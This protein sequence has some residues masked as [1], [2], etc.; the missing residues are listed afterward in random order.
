MGFQPKDKSY[1]ENKIDLDIIRK[2]VGDKVDCSEADRI[3][4][5]ERKR[6]EDRNKTYT[7]EIMAD[8]CLITFD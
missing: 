2:I 8:D 3:L 5:E 7:I 6:I 4:E 1:K